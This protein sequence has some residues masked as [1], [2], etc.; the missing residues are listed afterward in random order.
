MPYMQI[1]TNLKIAED[2]VESIMADISRQLAEELGKPESYVMVNVRD[3]ERL[4]FAGNSEPAAYVELK[5]IGLPETKTQ[6][7]ARFLCGFLKDRLAIDPARVY[8]EFTN[9]PGK[10]W[11]WNSGTF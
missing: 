5:S 4:L 3:G 11:G 2:Q 6:S 10:L 8:I 1:Q 7:L 9:I